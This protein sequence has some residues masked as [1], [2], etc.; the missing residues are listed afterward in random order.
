[1]S[2]YSV[3]ATE[4]AKLE[5]GAAGTV[6]SVL[7]AVKLVLT[8][9][10]GTVPMYRD[11]GIDMEFLDQPTPAAEQRARMDIREAVEAWEPRATVTDIT[12]AKDALHTGKLVPTVEVEINDD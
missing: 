9:P 1:M 3:S 5:L 12:F 2:V 6:K 4:D 8:T 11:F 7:Q 10:K